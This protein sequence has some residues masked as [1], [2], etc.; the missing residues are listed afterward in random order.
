MGLLDDLEQEAQRR[1]AS[2]GDAEQVK[3]EREQAFKT[4]LEP[5]LQAFHEYLAKLTANLAFLKPKTQLSFD[6]PGYG[7]V[8][9]NVEH[10]YDLRANTISPVS[11]EVVLLFSAN[12]ATDDCPTVQVQGAQKIRTLNS[13]FQKARLAGIAEFKKDEAGEMVQASFRARGKITLNVTVAADAES[14]VAR[15]SFT[16]FDSFGTITKS[17]SP[18][19]FDEKLF[20]E[21]GRFI[22]RETNSLFREA[23]PEDFRKQLAHK[24]QQEQLKRKWESKIAEQQ[25]A[26]LDRARKEQG[27]KGRFDK[28]VKDV[29]GAAPSILDRVKGLFNKKP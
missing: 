19:Q 17:A 4:R 24:V 1:K 28:A 3:L 22:A 5:G 16:N 25:A 6:I 15:L 26:D 12:V 18:Q 9:A 21:V 13:F 14:G 23:L 29:A 8:V 11:K 2:L 20:D 27:L 7:T 10:E